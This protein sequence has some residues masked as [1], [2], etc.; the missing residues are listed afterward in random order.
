MSDIPSVLLT[1]MQVTVLSCALAA[2]GLLAMFLHPSN[3]PDVSK[4]WSIG[5]FLFG[6]AVMFVAAAWLRPSLRRRK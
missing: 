2:A 3:D 4:F 6:V 5:P 1:R